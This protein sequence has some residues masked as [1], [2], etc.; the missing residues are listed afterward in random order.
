MMKENE[1]LK[2]EL[3]AAKTAKTEDATTQTIISGPIWATKIYP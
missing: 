3:A 1:R 2:D